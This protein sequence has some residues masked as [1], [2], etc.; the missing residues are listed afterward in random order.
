[1]VKIGQRFL[2]RGKDAFSIRIQCSIRICKRKEEKKKKFD[3]VK[4]GRSGRFSMLHDGFT[5]Y[6][7]SVNVT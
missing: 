4:F 6:Y 3:L 2:V 5:V 1:M 7:L